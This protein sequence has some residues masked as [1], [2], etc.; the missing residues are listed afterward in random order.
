MKGKVDLDTLFS[1]LELWLKRNSTAGFS[2]EVENGLHTCIMKHN[3]GLKWSL[4]HKVV[5][6]LMLKEILGDS[7]NMEVSMAENILIFKFRDRDTKYG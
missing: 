5:L 4:Y 3:L 6:E 7:L 1:W 2:Y